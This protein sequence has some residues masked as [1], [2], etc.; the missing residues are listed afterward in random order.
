[1]VVVFCRDDVN[2]KYNEIETFSFFVLTE[3][4]DEKKNNYDG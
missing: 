3:T 4:V 1:M 2:I